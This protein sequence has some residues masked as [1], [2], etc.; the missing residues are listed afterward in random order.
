MQFV[1]KNSPN[2]DIHGIR[3]TT[4]I[5]VPPSALPGRSHGSA[6]TGPPCAADTRSRTM[7]ARRSTRSPRRT[8]RRAARFSAIYTGDSGA[9]S[10]L[11][12]TKIQPL[13]PVP[14]IIKPVQPVPLTDRSQ[15]MYVPQPG[16]VNPYT[17][18]ITL[19]VT[20]SITSE[21]GCGSSLHRHARPEAAECRI[22]N[23]PA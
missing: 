14:T 22:S 6:P 23:Q 1:G 10:Y 9:N 12:L 8:S 20:R 5:L 15:Q 17:Q 2:P 11:D 7:A 3:P 16:F 21:P 18:N 13:V 19:A 4:I